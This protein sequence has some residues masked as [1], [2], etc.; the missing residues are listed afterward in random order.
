MSMNMGANK[1]FFGKYRGVV[2]D[3]DDPLKMGRIR[4]RVPDVH[5]DEQSGWAMACMPFAGHGMGF[6]G[7]PTVGGGVWIEFEQGDPD[8]PIWAGSWWPSG[9][10]LPGAAQSPP[11]KKTVIV[12]EKGNQV[13]LD[14]SSD[15][16]IMLQIMSGQTSIT[17]KSE[18]GTD[19]I[20]VKATGT[21][22]LQ[23][24]SGAKIALSATGIEL[25]NGMGASIKMEGPQVS[26]NGGALEII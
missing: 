11:Y 7:L 18:G 17:L 22:T 3:I 6:L 14:D 12:T 10:S 8:F 9:D 26:I 5:G 15:G 20:T 13:V 25:D 19:S 16:G 1:R 2:T 21:V 23:T 24:T 4:A